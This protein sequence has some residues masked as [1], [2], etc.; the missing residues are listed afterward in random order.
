[1]RGKKKRTV[2][3]A[4]CCTIAGLIAASSI[5]VGSALDGAEENEIEIQTL[6]ASE[7]EAS[8]DAE[9][10]AQTEEETETESETETEPASELI[11]GDVTFDKKV[12]LLDSIA[13]QK[14][15][16]SQMDFSD[17]QILCGDVD[18]NL[19]V[20]LMDSIMVQKFSLDQLDESCEIGK[21]LNPV[22]PTEPTEPTVSPTQP[23][24]PPTQPT[25]PPTQPIEPD[26]VELNKTSLTIGVGEKYTL[27]KSSPTGSDL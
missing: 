9:S 23:T 8:T 20:N 18:K 12:N 5:A 3:S 14:F 26:T 21:P 7:T 4:L 27:K 15:S 2:K 25:D 17:T 19:K 10:E 6:P 13:I 22:Q 11:L 16:L 24:E 1:M